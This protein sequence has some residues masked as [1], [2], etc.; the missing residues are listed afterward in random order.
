MGPF[1]MIL[2]QHIHDTID[3]VNN[4]IVGFELIRTFPDDPRSVEDFLLY[5]Q[6]VAK[7][8]VNDHPNHTHTG[9]LPRGMF[10]PFDDGHYEIVILPGQKYCWKRFVLCKELF[11]VLLDVNDKQKIF[12][13]R[14]V[15]SHI[16]QYMDKSNGLPNTPQNVQ[17]ETLAEIAAM[18][19]LFP[20][21]HRLQQLD[22]PSETLAH[23]YKIPKALVEKYIL[24]HYMDGLNPNTI[25][26]AAQ[27]D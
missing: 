13:N 2:Y 27:A 24:K 11:H 10:I 5:C 3:I 8:E 23:R 1:F 12:I 15:D 21:A 19:F 16:E 14:D 17:A 20:Y 4:S 18:E 6:S 9:A 25:K 22:T 7:I 26:A